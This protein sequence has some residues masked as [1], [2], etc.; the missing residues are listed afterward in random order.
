M[1]K[2]LLA[3]TSALIALALP[4]CL[5]NETTIHLNKDGS[6]TLVEETKLGAQMLAYLENGLWLDNAR[7]AADAGNPAA[8]VELGV[9]HHK[10][11]LVPQ[12]DKLAYEW[13]LAGAKAGNAS[14]QY[15]LAR[16]TIEGRGVDQA[17]DLQGFQAA[18]ARHVGDELAGQFKLDDRASSREN[19]ALRDIAA[20]ANHRQALGC[21]SAEQIGLAR[22]HGLTVLKHHAEIELLL[23]EIRPGGRCQTQLLQTVAMTDDTQRRLRWAR[24]P[25][26]ANL[27]RV[28]ARR[29]AADAVLLLQH[30][31]A[32]DRDPGQRLARGDGGGGRTLARQVR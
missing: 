11:V 19:V 28:F 22:Y 30:A 7:R 15:A 10:G 8:K 31:G 24:H 1:K 18:I 26:D 27:N 23:A 9:L 13:Y 32:F 3:A 16:M 14:A 21:G 2:L 12:D 25:I 5:Q 6:G 29:Q 17:P 4:G 20:S